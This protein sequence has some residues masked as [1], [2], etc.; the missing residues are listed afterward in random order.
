VGEGDVCHGLRWE[1]DGV[2]GTMGKG[3]GGTDKTQGVGGGCKIKGE[4][5]QGWQW[6]ASCLALF[7]GTCSWRGAAGD[8]S[9]GGDKG[10]GK[11]GGMDKKLADLANVR[12]KETSEDQDNVDERGGRSP[13]RCMGNLNHRVM[14]GQ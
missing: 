14:G 4:E 11:G 13:V 9:H 1:E 12:R 5:G 7:G 2:A 10:N 6:G 8:C 3:G